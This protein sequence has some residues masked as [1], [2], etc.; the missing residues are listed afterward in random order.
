VLEIADVMPYLLQR[1]LISARA[2]VHDRLRIVDMSRR[3]RVF[4]VTADGQPGLVVKSHADDDGVRHEAVVLERLRAGNPRL[5]ARLPLPISFDRSA[6]VLVLEAAPDA[7][8]LRERH[9]RGRFSRELAAQA[10]RALALLHATPLAA[11]GE[12][13]APWDPGWAL[14][15]HRP[16][17]KTAQHMLTGAASELVKT[18]QRSQEL[19]AALDHLHLSCRD[20]AVIHGDVRWENVLTARPPRGTSSRRSRV[21]LVDWESAGRGDPSLDLGTFFGEY[22]HAWLRSIPIV[23]PKEPGRLLAHAGCPLAH[24]RPAVGAFWLSYTRHSAAAAPELGRLLRRAASYA[25]VRVLTSAYEES[26]SRHELGGSAHFALQL[27]LNILRR[28]DE[29]IAHLLGLSASWTQQ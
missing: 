18:I 20:G 25:A 1:D 21:L 24:M 10:G 8:D 15:L 13:A 4:I 3:N 19:C 23:D 9:A 11:L 27:S 28:P 6:G 7:Q 12:Q 14:R 2:V 26:L 16:S 17:L 22:L 5:A 29:A